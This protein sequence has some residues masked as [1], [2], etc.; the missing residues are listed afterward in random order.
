MMG[1]IEG[2]RRG[3]RQLDEMVGWHH[4]FNGYELEQTPGVGEDQGGL[5]CC[6]PWGDK[7]L[8]MTVQQQQFSPPTTDKNKQTNKISPP[9]SSFYFN[10]FPIHSSPLPFKKVILFVFYVSILIRNYQESNY[11]DHNSC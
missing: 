4:Q 3:G 7:E 5:A 9:D 8:D 2:R 11:L 1:K 10:F 6:G